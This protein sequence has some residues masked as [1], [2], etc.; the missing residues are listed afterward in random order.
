MVCPLNVVVKE[1]SLQNNHIWTRTFVSWYTLVQNIKPRRF[2][3]SMGKMLL[4]I[5]ML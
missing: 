5:N 3:Y 4:D 2:K 1:L